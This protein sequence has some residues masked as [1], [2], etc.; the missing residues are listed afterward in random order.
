MKRRL[1]TAC[2]A[3]LVIG[4]AGCQV[5]QEQAAELPD[6]DVSVEGGRWPDY[7]VN[8]ADVDVGTEQRTITV[9]VVNVQKEQREV[10]VPYV[11]V[12]PPGGGEIEERTI[13]MDLNVPHAGYSVQIVELRA[14]DDDLWVI[15]RL[16]ESGGAGAQVLSQVSDRVVI[17][18][19]ADLDVRKVVI[20]TRPSGVGNTE[21]Q[22]VDSMAALENSIPQNARVLYRRGGAAQQ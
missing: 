7:D 18:A 8:W 2:A 19:P 12:S 3:V 22:F 10:T 14:S 11:R 15:G 1:G 4:A 6:A 13:A 21:V 16:D 5:E 17:D 20:G 9:P